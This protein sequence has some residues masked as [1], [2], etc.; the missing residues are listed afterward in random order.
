MTT[1]YRVLAYLLALQ[2]VVQAAAI[3]WA[4]SGLVNWVSDGGTLDTAAMESGETLFAEVTGFMVHGMNG[5]MLIP[6]VAVL[7]LVVSFF[8]KVPR[9]VAWAA[10]VLGL[11]V[12]QVLLGMFLHGSS[13]A[14]LLHGA[15]ALVLFAVALQAGRRVRTS[16]PNAADRDVDRTHVVS[17]TG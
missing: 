2:V 11:V 7:L 9:G 13:F 15:N 17:T 6:L 4:F 12:V 8:A 1:A 14:G 3:A 10:G 5:M 16:A